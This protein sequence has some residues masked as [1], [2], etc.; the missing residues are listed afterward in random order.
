MDARIDYDFPDGRKLTFSGGVA[1]TEGIMHSGIG[2]FDIDSGTLMGYGKVN[3][4]RRGFRAGFFTNIL[5]GDARNLLTRTP[6]N[7]PIGFNFKTK[8]FDLELG[9]VTTFGQRHAVSYGGNL[10]FNRFEMSLAPLA[11]DRTE[12]GVYAQDEIF[13]NEQ[14]R[15]VVGGARRS[16]RLP[17]RHRLLAADHADDQ[18]AREPHVQACRTTART[19]RRR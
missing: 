14:F 13:I 18:A 7:E 3:F 2:P 5:D 11:D 16:L 19:A 12:F 8:T 15:W 1:G 9:N 10:R 6:T 17:G 4:T